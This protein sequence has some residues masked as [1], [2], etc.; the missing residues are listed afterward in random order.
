MSAK[1]I[2]LE[3]GYTAD[4]DSCNKDEWHKIIDQFSDAN[5]YQTWSYDAIRCGEDNITHFKLHKDNEIVAAAQARL[6][7]I[8]VFG[9]GAAYIRWGPLWQIRHQDKDPFV[10][11]MAV[12]A[13]RNEY[14]CRLGLILRIFP[15]LYDDNSDLLNTLLEEGYTPTAKESS[16]RTLILDVQPPI[17]ELRRNFMQKWRNCLNKAERNQLELIE[18]T[19]DN[20][21]EKFIGIYREL[22][23]RKKFKEPNDINEFR[24]I[25]HDLPIR[26]KMGIFLSG[27]N[28]INSSGAIFSS[29]GDTGVYLFGATNDEGMKNNGSYLLQWQSIHWMK[30]SGC[31]YYNLNG[32]NPAINPGTYHFKAGVAGKSGE[33]VRYLGHFDCYS[34]AISAALARIADVVF[35][36]IKKIISTSGLKTRSNPKR[37]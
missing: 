16:Q 8:P 4:F 29:I 1:P 34:S 12:R 5:I 17:E 33:D 24:M 15:V 25:Q 7:R 14:V 2:P 20:L 22:L 6:V 37:L 11:R 28:G 31:R 10:F 9:F 35:P 3:D 27:S 18:G 19:E 36:L 26:M 21:F 30:K 32:I 23:Q 13:L